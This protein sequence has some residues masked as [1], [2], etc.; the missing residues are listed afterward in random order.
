MG[1]VLD[2]W[3]DG[4]TAEGRAEASGLFGSVVLDQYGSAA[5]AEFTDMRAL[6]SSY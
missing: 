3:G 2:A 1:V 6:D 4:V 5:S